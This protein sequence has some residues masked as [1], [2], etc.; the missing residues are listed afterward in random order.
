MN[1]LLTG[2]TG[3]L[4][5]YL[6]CELLSRGHAVRALYRNESRRSKTCKFLESL[7]LPRRGDM[8]EWIRCPLLELDKRWKEL[9]GLHPGLDE[10]DNVLHCA[11][12]TRLFLDGSG[13]P[14]KTNIEGAAMLVRLLDQRPLKLHLISTAYVCG[15]VHGKTVREV[16]HPRGDFV[17][18]YEESKWEAEQLLFG[19]ATFLRPSII[20]GHSETGRCTSFTGWYILLKAAHLLDRLLQDNPGEQRRNL[21]VELPADPDSS[22]NIVPVDYVAR[23]AVTILE[24]PK[25]HNGLFH[26]THPNPPTNQWIMQYICKRFKLDGIRLA[27]GGKGPSA[28]DSPFHRLAWSQ[29][30]PVLV[31]FSNNP[32]FDRTNTDK[33]T[34]DIEVPQ[35]TETLVARL[36]D[37]AIA[38]DWND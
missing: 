18:V 32:V 5:E 12:S 8:L 9:G 38:A 27:G 4:G 23:G 11:A 24:N 25:N 33:A 7:G 29:L 34:P 28:A 20:V 31:H 19:K 16:N 1:V 35:I 22:I 15:L 30:K 36:L 6:L 17:T 26:L 2:A 3:F 37:N 10:V 21:D 14:L 13:D